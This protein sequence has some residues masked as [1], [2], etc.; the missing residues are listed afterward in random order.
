V[1]VEILP[2]AQ[3]RGAEQSYIFTLSE[4]SS[5]LNQLDVLH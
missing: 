1:N 4:A 3:S 5:I 2:S